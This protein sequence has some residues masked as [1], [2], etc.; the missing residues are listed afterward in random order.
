MDRHF[1]RLYK[2]AS[3]VNGL[4]GTVDELRAKSNEPYNMTDYGN[5]NPMTDTEK[6]VNRVCHPHGQ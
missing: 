2:H 6:M 5:L 4:P 3:L 1:A